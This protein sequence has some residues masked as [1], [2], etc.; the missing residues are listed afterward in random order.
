MCV[1]FFWGST[2]VAI[3][4]A[5]ETMPPFWM[6]GIRFLIA[7]SALY[8]FRRW[9]GDRAP[10]GRE[11]A[12]A[13]LLGAMLLVCGNGAVV[14]AEQYV[15]SGITS[16]LIATT[17]LWLTIISS[18]LTRKLPGFGS[19][20]A[21]LL[22][23]GGILLLI[24]PW[25]QDGSIHLP[26]ALAINTS[27]MLWAVAPLIARRLPRSSSPLLETSMEMLADG[28]GL[29]ILATLNGDWARV[30]LAAISL[31]SL[32]GMAYLIIFGSLVGF[33]AYSFLLTAAPPP[34]VATYAYVNPMVAIAVGALLAGEV[35]TPRVLAAAIV[36]VSSVVLINLGEHK[37]TQ[38]VPDPAE[39]EQAGRAE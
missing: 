6:A 14:W 29:T 34:V 33:S 23:F 20:A 32:G 38:V 31:R 1:Y 28:A 21:V 15:P 10:A 4:F 26:G 36:I 13:A 9:R 7:G 5:I 27:A 37:K 2:Y 11:W 25:Q 3:R 30:D 24:N 18:L 17:P 39:I 12:S 19:L 22:G 35:I 8:L 16:L